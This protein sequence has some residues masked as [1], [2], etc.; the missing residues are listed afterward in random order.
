M[1]TD[2]ARKAYRD[3]HATSSVSG[4]SPHKLVALLFDACQENL[5]TAK[6]AMTR[7]DTK[8]KAEALKKAMDVIV[9]LQAVLD[10][11]KGG[12]IATRLDD[13]YT[14][15]TNRLA[16]AN[17]VNDTAMVDEVF[18]VIAELKLGWNE[19]GKEVS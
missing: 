17:A 13:L 3:T 10:F 16:L 6:G 9:Q 5:A 14:F 11:E 7:G 12:V 8:K 19:I 1:F 2:D 18:R 15:C 4:A